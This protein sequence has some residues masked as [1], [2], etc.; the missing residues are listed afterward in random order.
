[1]GDY[2]GGGTTEVERERIFDRSEI[3]EFKNKILREEF[4]GTPDDPTYANL[5]TTKLICS[6]G[7]SIHLI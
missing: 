6:E 5:A 4:M 1:M 3:V 7:L 2:R